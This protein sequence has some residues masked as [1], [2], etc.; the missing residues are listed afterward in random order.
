M[1][2]DTSEEPQK[3]QESMMRREKMDGSYMQIYVV[4]CRYSSSCI[5][6][7]DK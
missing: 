2:R 4:I 3:P 5:D 1:S 6:D 7:S